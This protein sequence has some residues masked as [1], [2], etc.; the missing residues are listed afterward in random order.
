[1]I[2][3]IE[4]CSRNRTESF[5]TEMSSHSGFNTFIKSTSRCSRTNDRLQLFPLNWTSMQCNGL[6]FLP[7]SFFLR[8]S[9]GGNIDWRLKKTSETYINLFS[10]QVIHWN[11]TGSYSSEEQPATNSL[12]IKHL[13]GKGLLTCD[14]GLLMNSQRYTLEVMSTNTHNTSHPWK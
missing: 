9:L 11:M 12:Q 8:N 2:G 3:F 5:L 1:M 7:A 10:K 4:T 13:Q 14:T 6:S